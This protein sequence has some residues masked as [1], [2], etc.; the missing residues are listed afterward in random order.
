MEII[1][2]DC[3]SPK[4]ISTAKVNQICQDKDLAMCTKQSEFIIH[5]T[6]IRLTKRE[7]QYNVSCYGSNYL[8]YVYETLLTPKDEKVCPHLSSAMRYL[9]IFSETELICQ[10][11]S[12][13][14]LKK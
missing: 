10:Q 7:Q 6:V 12:S 8:F 13:M 9:R 2:G 4:S 1:H 11:L 3:Y 14:P 5:K